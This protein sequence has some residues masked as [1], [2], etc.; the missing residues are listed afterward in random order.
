MKRL[1]N[2]EDNEPLCSDLQLFSSPVL[3]VIPKRKKKMINS[4]FFFVKYL[5]F[6][7]PNQA[8]WQKKSKTNDADA[9]TGYLSICSVLNLLLDIVIR[10]T[11]V[12][13]NLY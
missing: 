8:E 3:K 11:C 1:K 9:Y 5:D 2:F 12:N 7:T 10:F 6:G 4:L 13:V